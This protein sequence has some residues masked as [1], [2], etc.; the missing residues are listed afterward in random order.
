MVRFSA[1]FGELETLVLPALSPATS[2]TAVLSE[3]SFSS[4]SS[5]TQPRSVEESIILERS[6]LSPASTT[7]NV[8]DVQA[9]YAKRSSPNEPFATEYGLSLLFDQTW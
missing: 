3:A 9:V 2:G 1:E 8:T 6:L 7:R 5:R 4:P